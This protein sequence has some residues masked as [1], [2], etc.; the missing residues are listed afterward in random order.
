M[1]RGLGYSLDSI[2]ARS[3]FR[4]IYVG[5]WLATAFLMLVA[6]IRVHQAVLGDMCAILVLGQVVGRIVSLGLDGMP[7]ARIWPMF[8][9]EALGAVA[10]LVVRPSRTQE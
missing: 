2:D 3:E 5:L 7:S 10:L 6:L 4:A 9:L 8:V 1:A